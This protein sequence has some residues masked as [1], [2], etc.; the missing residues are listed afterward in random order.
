LTLM[1]VDIEGIEDCLFMIHDIWASIIEFGVGIF[2]LASVMGPSCV[3][4]LV[5]TASKLHR[6]LDLYTI[7]DLD[8][9]FYLLHGQNDDAHGC[10][11]T[12]M[13]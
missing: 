2:I 13:E 10:S 6:R 3:F 8:S 12:P 1:S 4:V 11:K 9:S 5:P 7:V